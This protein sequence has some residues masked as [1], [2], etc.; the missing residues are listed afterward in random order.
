MKT[1][2][3]QSFHCSGTTFVR[4]SVRAY[5]PD[6]LS[7]FHHMHLLLYYINLFVTP[8][9]T[10]YIINL[11]SCYKIAD[12][13]L[14][15]GCA[16]GPRTRRWRRHRPWGQ[17]ILKISAQARRSFG[18]S[19]SVVRSFV[20]SSSLLECHALSPFIR[21]FLHF[22]QLVLGFYGINMYET[23][24]MAKRDQGVKPSRFERC[25][26]SASD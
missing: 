15:S 17:S 12:G 23:V 10:I 3:T 19:R 24:W 6:T 21:N 20:P 16:V 13:R 26:D 9:H 4:I 25:T 1:Y 22:I 7:I 18:R 8:G 2:Q 14:P 11:W 5:P